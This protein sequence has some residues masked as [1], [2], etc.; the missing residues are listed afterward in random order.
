ML[1][2]LFVLLTYSESYE[3]YIQYFSIIATSTHFWHFYTYSSSF[4]MDSN[5]LVTLIRNNFSCRR[6]V[7]P[8][9]DLKVINS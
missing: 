4:N 9:A 1:H 2:V 8:R 7:S 3:F 6:I 5:V